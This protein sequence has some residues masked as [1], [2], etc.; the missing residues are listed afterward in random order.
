MPQ[1]SDAAAPAG[2]F[3]PE[4]WIEDARLRTVR[5]LLKTTIILSALLTA[6]GFV[7]A[8]YFYGFISLAGLSVYLV[9]YLRLPRWGGLRVAYVF[10]ITFN[11]VTLLYMARGRGIFSVNIVLIP[12]GMFIGALILERRHVHFLFGSLVLAVAGIGFWKIIWPGR[13]RVML[14]AQPPEIVI[15]SLMLVV[16]SILAWIIVEALREMFVE[17]TRAEAATRQARQ[18]VEAR[19][20]SLQL[21]SDL[22]HRLQRGLTIDEIAHEAIEVLQRLSRPPLVAVYLLNEEQSALE[23]VAQEGFGSGIEAG[24]QLPLSGSLSGTALQ[25]E[26]L[27]YSHDVGS[28]ER[29]EP[30]LRGRLARAGLKSAVAIPLTAGKSFGTLNLV[31]SDHREFTR[32]ELGTFEAVGQAVALGIASARHLSDLEHQ[33][34]H[35]ALTGLPN[36]ASFFQ[37]FDALL[38]TSRAQEKTAAAVVDIHRF[39]DVNDALGHRLSDDLIRKFAARLTAITELR[40]G[41]VFRIGGGEFAL[42]FER[43]SS[44]EQA[45]KYLHEVV[46]TMRDA[47]DVGGIA[48][49]VGSYG[50]FAIAPDDATSGEEIL[51]R[52]HVALRSA[53]TTATPALRYSVQW[54][55][56]APERLSLMADLARALH[57]DEITLHFQPIVEIA[58]G[59]VV[60]FEALVR[61]EHPTMGL[62]LPGVFL[63]LAEESDLINDLTDLVVAK[64]MAQ[65]HEWHSRYPQL[66]MSVNL[67]ARNLLDRNCSH[68]LL[69]IIQAAEVE[70]LQVAFELTETAVM[71]DRDLALTMLSRITGTGAH[72]AIDDFGTGYSSLTYLRH[73]PVSEIKIDRSFVSDMADGGQSHAIVRSTIQL[74]RSLG[75][76]VVAEGIE[77]QRTADALGEIGCPYA[78]GYFFARP[79]PAAVIERQMLVGDTLRFVRSA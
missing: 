28:D 4:N 26:G 54:D 48:L 61:W 27:L 71:T 50:G 9:L 7:F 29:I 44:A 2:T 24:H 11:L 75:L 55:Q 51:R 62:L 47:V 25:K 34:F 17:R 60:S 32:M 36:R 6:L 13:L 16:A 69:E 43:L 23:L 59:A 58:S 41:R 18:E 63:P 39:R 5:A 1:R 19:N 20:E 22:T 77:D 72:L 57:T 38:A 76:N 56:N 65:L 30:D 12:A 64:S 74:A 15:V 52:A 67:S 10:T 33:A 49:N 68:R 35:D 66:H 31:Y 45:A 46:I 70:P 37:K 3:V 78:Q 73:F 8:N 53:K 21:I 40:G 79:A 14:P 42:L